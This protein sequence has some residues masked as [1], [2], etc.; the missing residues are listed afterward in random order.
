MRVSGVLSL[1]VE[2]YGSWLGLVSTPG[3]IYNPACLRGAVKDVSRA[4][5]WILDRLVS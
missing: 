1:S 2:A 4:A 3:A 5:L